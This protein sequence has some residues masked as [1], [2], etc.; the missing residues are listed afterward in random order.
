[1]GEIADPAAELSPALIADGPDPEVR[2]NARQALQRIAAR[3][4]NARS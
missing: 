1:M 2:K 3:R 4:A